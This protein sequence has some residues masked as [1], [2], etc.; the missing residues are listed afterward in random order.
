MTGAT[1]LDEAAQPG[2]PGIVL[3]SDGLGVTPPNVTC[4]TEDGGFDHEWEFQ[5]ESF[6]HEYGCEQ[7]HFWRCAYCGETKGMESGDYGFDDDC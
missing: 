7:V 2:T 1:E 6:D 5:D 3:S 4:Q